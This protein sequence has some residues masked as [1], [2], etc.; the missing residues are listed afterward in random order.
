MNTEGQLDAKTKQ[1]LSDAANLLRIDSIKSTD[2]AGSGLVYI[3]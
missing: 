1:A 3:T 2:A